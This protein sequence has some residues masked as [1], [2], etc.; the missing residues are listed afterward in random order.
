M[1]WAV[2]QSYFDNGRVRVRVRQ[3]EEGEVARNEE[4]TRCDFYVDIFDSKKE[5]E[6]FAADAKLA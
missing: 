2:E 4:R 6:Q 5:A 3:A 1:K